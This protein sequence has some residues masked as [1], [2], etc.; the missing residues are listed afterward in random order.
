VLY[1]LTVV[2]L[3]LAVALLV[4]AGWYAARNRL[5]DDRVLG[6][7]ALLEVALLVQLVVTVAHLG[8]VPGGGA[9]K[10]TFA[11]YAITLPFVTPAAVFLALKEKTRWAMVVV[12]VGAFAAAVMTA[13]L[14]QIWSLR[15]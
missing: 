7:A 9:E 4:I 15:G 13:R 2:V 10:A 8:G 1:P 6:T 3:V 11:A 12:A 14:Q 5:L